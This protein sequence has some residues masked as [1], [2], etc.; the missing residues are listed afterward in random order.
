MEQ[1]AVADLTLARKVLDVDPGA[2]VDLGGI[3]TGEQ[4][5]AHEANISRTAIPVVLAPDHRYG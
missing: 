4:I 1:S 5:Q 2:P 3:L